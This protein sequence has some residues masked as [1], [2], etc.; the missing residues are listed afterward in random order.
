[1]MNYLIHI[2]T[3]AERDMA[4]AADYIEFV[5]KNPQAAD[6][7]L[8]EADRQINDLAQFPK[9]FPLVND[10]LLASWGIRFTKVNN[11]LAFY[12]VSEEDRRV[13]IVRFLYGKS[14]WTSILRL[15]LPLV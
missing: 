11:Y 14:N 2:T 3:T 13:N 1:M 6:H 8:D 4:Q 7:L 9:K 15:G 10:K 5:L 12:I